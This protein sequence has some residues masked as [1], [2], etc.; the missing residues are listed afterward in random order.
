MRGGPAGLLDSSHSDRI[1]DL[2]CSPAG[3]EHAGTSSSRTRSAKILMSLY[4]I[5]FAGWLL[6]LPG[7]ISPPA[8]PG[9]TPTADSAPVSPADT[10]A[11]MPGADSVLSRDSAALADSARAG[12]SARVTTD[13]LGA[14]YGT[15]GEAER[16][17]ASV[18]APQ[19]V[20]SILSKACGGAEGSATLARDLLVIVFAPEAGRGDRAALISEVGGKLLGPVSSE[21]GAYYLRVPTGGQEHRLRAAADELVRS[22][23]VR[24]V[25]T[26]AC[27][28]PAPADT[29]RATAADTSRPTA[30][31]T[32]RPSS[33]DTSR[34]PPAN[35]PPTP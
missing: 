7:L 30:A 6:A 27:P 35:P 17:S 24:Q 23:L 4:H 19:P 21:P 1:R 12:D 18:P 22:G 8:A 26:R 28:S 3:G 14:R 16:P 13:S 25:G 31:D 34:P 33:A 20:D 29:G 10:L 5:A 2:A 11:R 9:Q 32:S 15:A